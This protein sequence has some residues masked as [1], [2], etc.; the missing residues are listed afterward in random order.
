MFCTKCNEVI[1]PVVAIDIDG[2]L[3]N[4]IGHF[5]KHAQG[6]LGVEGLLPTTYDG[7]MGFKEW[8]CNSWGITEDVWSDIKLTYRQGAWKRTMPWY[9]GSDN[10][11]AE[12]RERAELWLTTTRPYLRHDNIDPDTR[13]W[14]RRN[15]IKYDGLIYD[16]QK[17]VQLSNIVGSNRVCAVL[18]DLAEEIAW[19]SAIFGSFVPILRSTPHNKRANV[20]S[21]TPK[22]RDMYEALDL[23]NANIDKWEEQHA[24]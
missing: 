14:L 24:R 22:A 7:S 2:T 15:N 6:Y 9:P 11:C 4:Y 20:P 13:E 21:Y 16:E 8:C 17:Y 12:I 18:D 19:A 23:I 1:K 10:A 3:G 5:T